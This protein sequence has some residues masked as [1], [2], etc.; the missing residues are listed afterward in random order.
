MRPKGMILVRKEA[1]FSLMKRSGI[2]LD[3]HAHDM[4][5]LK[6]RQRMKR[7]IYDLGQNAEILSIG[8]AR[9]ADLHSRDDDPREQLKRLFAASVS[10]RQ[11]GSWRITDEFFASDFA[12]ARRP[13]SA[14]ERG[15]AIRTAVW[16]FIESHDARFVKQPATAKCSS[17]KCRECARLR[18]W[19]VLALLYSWNEATGIQRSH[20]I[21][22]L[23]HIG[24]DAAAQRTNGAKPSRDGARPRGRSGHPLYDDP[25]I[26]L[27]WS[28]S[29]YKIAKRAAL[30]ALY[31]HLTDPDDPVVLKVLRALPGPTP[32]PEPEPPAHDPALAPPPAPSQRVRMAQIAVAEPPA[33]PRMPTLPN[34]P[35]TLPSVTRE[36]YHIA[37]PS[38]KP[39]SDPI[40]ATQTGVP[41]PAPPG[42]VTPTL[43]GDDAITLPRPSRN[44][45]MRLSWQR[46]VAV[47]VVIAVLVTCL[48]ITSAPPF[49]GVLT[50]GGANLSGWLVARQSIAR[51]QRILAV[52]NLRTG[53][54]RSIWPPAGVADGQSPA[55]QPLLGTD[56]PTAP[57]F[58]PTGRRLAFIAKDS[59]QVAA[60]FVATLAIGADGW[61]EIAGANPRMLLECDCS[62]LAWSPSGQWLIFNSPSGLMAVDSDGKNSRSLTANGHD[63]FPACSP[64][65]RYLAYQREGGS[66]VALPTRDCLP[67]ASTA[68]RM[69]YLNGYSTAWNPSWSPDSQMLSFV[70]N[71]AGRSTVYVT[72][73]ANLTD[74]P[75]LL[76]RD[77]AQPVSA[78][79]CG[80]PVW[81]ARGGGAE[82]PTAIVFGCDQPTPDDH[83]G[84]LGASSGLSWPRWT[85]SLSEGIANRDSLCWI[86]ANLQV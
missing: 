50:W 3:F 13:E 42:I 68:G 38:A 4:P 15:R 1:N 25:V 52:I 61:P 34:D 20:D 33:P 82:T 46:W 64:D 22:E 40:S 45:G 27:G 62:S 10:D 23:I 65:G 63:A 5:Q 19:H 72:P 54:W 55:D 76:V 49:T 78:S 56:S 36:G 70:S 29:T 73:L 26:Q 12:R 35:I 37:I 43:P 84:T 32:T 41:P 7:A 85:A 8:R 67:D 18:Q 17:E 74:H 81:A 57:A 66:I 6:R 24:Q 9:M 59:Q 31:T 86:P 58:M 28:E 16:R 80:N 71:V 21:R 60:I 48:N 79:G 11:V 83:H 53:A 14:A 75:L 47:A 77:T 30:D 2:P 44:T 39:M 51:E 69:R